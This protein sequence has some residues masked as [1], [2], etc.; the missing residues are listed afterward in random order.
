MLTF[1]QPNLQH[2]EQVI[3]FRR[4]F[5]AVFPAL[6]GANELNSFT[7]GGIVGWFNYL[8]TPAG[9]QWFEYQKVEDSTYLAIKNEKVVGIMN[10]RHQLNDFLLAYGGHLGYSTHPHFQGQGMATQMV[11]FAKERFKALGL[12][13]ILI[14]CERGN[15]ASQRVILKS[16]GKLENCLNHNGKI[17][18][19]YWVALN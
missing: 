14:T 11:A 10:L 3:E 13:Q 1:I 9:T 15:L 17:I 2:R 5:N 7:D 12:T 18:E 4:E 19:R 6:H 8:N 16:G